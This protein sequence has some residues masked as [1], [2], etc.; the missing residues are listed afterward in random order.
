MPILNDGNS[1]MTRYIVIVVH[2]VFE[3]K[4]RLKMMSFLLLVFVFVV[5]MRAVYIICSIHKGTRKACAKRCNPVKTAVVIGSGGHT[6]EILK[7]LQNLN[8]GNDSPRV[9][10]MASTDTSS[11][12]KIHQTEE[13][14]FSHNGLS[15]YEIVKIPRSRNVG[16]MYISSVFT[17]LFA[18]LE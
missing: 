10:I 1:H 5:G 13:T 12:V 7:L 2:E 8:S 11:E 17:T 4:L 16:H 6:A 18:L 14:Y 15:T 3:V 9:Y